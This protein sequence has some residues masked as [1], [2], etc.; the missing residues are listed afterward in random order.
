MQEGGWGIGLHACDDHVEAACCAKAGTWAS[1]L[2][3]GE[4]ELAGL[5]THWIEGERAGQSWACCHGLYLGPKPGS[6]LS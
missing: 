4:G 3:A 6:N 5:L 2:L 1:K